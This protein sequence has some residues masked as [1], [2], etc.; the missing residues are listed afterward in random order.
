MAWILTK[1]EF[2]EDKTAPAL[3]DAYPKGTL[4]KSPKPKAWY[5]DI[6]SPETMPVPQALCQG[7]AR[8]YIEGR[9]LCYEGFFLRAARV[10]P[11]P[12]PCK[13]L[14]RPQRGRQAK[15]ARTCTLSPDVTAHLIGHQGDHVGHA[16]IEDHAENQP[17]PAARFLLDD[18]ERHKAGR[19][20][21]HEQH[22][23][24]RRSL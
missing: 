4:P 19:I 22:E 21:E 1:I 23:G 8:A 7:A 5:T 13:R 9:M 15:R 14:R 24:K 2:F 17:A 16:G 3:E 10:A 18:H 6:D 12:T 20:H 11:R